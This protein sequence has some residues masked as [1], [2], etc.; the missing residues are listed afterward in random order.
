MRCDDPARAAHPQLDTYCSLVANLLDPKLTSVYFALFATQDESLL[1]SF[2]SSVADSNLG[3]HLGSIV[4]SPGTTNVAER[5]GYSS[6][7]ALS[8]QSG[9]V[10]QSVS[11][12]TLTLQANSLSLYRLLANQYVFQYCPGGGMDCQGAWASFLNR[13]S[14]SGVLLQMAERER[15]SRR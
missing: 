13:I 14:G 15:R 6:V 5:S 12:N 2:L 11:G 8:L 4:S 10:T 3:T 9:A 1:S 7:L